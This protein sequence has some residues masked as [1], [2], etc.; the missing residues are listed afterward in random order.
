[1]ETWIKGGGNIWNY[2]RDQMDTFT[3]EKLFVSIFTGQGIFLTP[4]SSRYDP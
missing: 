3:R 2:G 4:L 1:M